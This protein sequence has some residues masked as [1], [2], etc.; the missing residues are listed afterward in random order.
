MDVTQRIGNPAFY[1][2]DAQLQGDGQVTCV[3]K[4]AGQVVSRATAS[5]S[6]NIASC[7]IVGDGFGG[8]VDANSG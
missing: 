5:G 2:I 6:Y 8:W 4:V 7:E 3:I 1:A